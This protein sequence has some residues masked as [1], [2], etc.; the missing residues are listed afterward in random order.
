MSKNPAPETFLNSF[1]DE[2]NNGNLSYLLSLYETDA[3]YVSQS[4]EIV[5]GQEN[6]RQILQR[7]IDMKGKLE[8]SVKNVFNT[9]DIALAISEWSFSGI[10]PDGKAVSLRGKSADVLRQ[11]SDGTWRIVIDNPWG[12][13][14]SR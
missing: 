3:C 7:F 8:T 9:R 14:I 12:V 13:D 4:G 10:G 2:L 1:A 6:I 5:K 11:Q